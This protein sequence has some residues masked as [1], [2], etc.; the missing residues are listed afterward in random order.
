MKHIKFIYLLFIL[1]CSSKDIFISPD[2][3]SQ[4]IQD[5]IL[6]ISA[7][8]EFKIKHTENVFTESELALINK[9][10][11]GTINEQLKP[12]LFLQTSLSK[13]EFID[14]KSKVSL[15]ESKLEFND[16][17]FFSFKIPKNKISLNEENSFVLFIESFSV[18]IFKKER[19]TS[20]PA[21]TYSISNPTPAE[22]KLAPAKLADQIM[23]CDF[24]YLIWDNANQKPVIYGFVNVDSK[25]QE[26]DDIDKMINRIVDKISS[27]L[28]K[29][30]P[31]KI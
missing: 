6:Y 12:N 10:L 22:T 26:N 5:A 28:I 29:N 31:F 23:S 16:D 4:K 17:S 3:K 13:I 15:E 2:Y 8:E 14:L 1:G 7:I 11:I 25:F 9:K 18:S 27:S 24:K 30:S 20:D 19:E 21:K